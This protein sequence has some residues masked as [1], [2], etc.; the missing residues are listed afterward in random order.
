MNTSLV[1]GLVGA[2]VG[3]GALLIVA[4]ATGTM[5]RTPRPGHIPV[6]QRVDRLLLRTL[7]T[8]V[9]VAV[10]GLWT[11]WVAAAGA[12]GLAGWCAPSMIN[13]R[14][15]QALLLARP[16]AVALWC[17]MLRDLLESSTGLKG[18][19]TASARVAPL[20]IADE[21]RGLGVR[22][23]R[24]DLQDALRLFAGEV[25]DPVCDTVVTALIWSI[26]QPVRNLANLLAAVA[27]S[28]RETVAMQRRITAAR[29]RTYR[30]SQLIAWIVGGFMTLLIV[31]NRS[32]LAPFG[33]VT[34]Q[35]VLL[36]VIGLI[37]ASIVAMVR[38]AKPARPERLLR[39][40][41]SRR[42]S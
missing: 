20:A 27:G 13:L 8:V 33:T 39:L 21:V 19:I 2:G 37:V 6:S 18:A 11:H 25:D 1:G 41:T 24:G 10:I 30:T 34:G 35:L 5:T 9:G 32:Y 29:A 22:A 23:G 15:S 42:S 17:E 38:L 7:L 28:T 3:L 4:G 31:T 14:G 40:D 12:A 26:D 36:V 16:E